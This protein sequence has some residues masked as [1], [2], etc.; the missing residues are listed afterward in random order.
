M[1]GVACGQTINVTQAFV[2]L[3]DP[4]FPERTSPDSFPPNGIVRS[5][6]ACCKEVTPMARSVLAN[7]GRDRPG[8]VADPDCIR[9]HAYSLASNFQL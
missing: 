9:D 7:H 1:T 6:V 8:K 3:I 2:T 4:D 5:I